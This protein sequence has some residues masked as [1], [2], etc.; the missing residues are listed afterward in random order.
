[1]LLIFNT[2]AIV[3]TYFKYKIVDNQHKVLVLFILIVLCFTI[4]TEIIWFIIDIISLAGTNSWN[5]I[6][7]INELRVITIIGIACDLVVIPTDVISTYLTNKS[8]KH[9]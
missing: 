2:V 1:M 6:D 8:I 3:F 4:T 9:N 5:S 7:L